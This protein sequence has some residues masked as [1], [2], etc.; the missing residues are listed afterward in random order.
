[1]REEDYIFDY[2]M[3]DK[4]NEKDG[5]LLD[6]EKQYLK[7]VEVKEITGHEAMDCLK[8]LKRMD[9]NI[10][11]TVKYLCQISNDTVEI[12]Q[13]RESYKDD[14]YPSIKDLINKPIRNKKEIIEYMKGCK[15][16]AAAPAVVIDLINPEIKLGELY[17]MT[18][19]KYS[20]R[21]DV[22]YYF[23]KYDMELPEEFIHHALRH[24]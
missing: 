13:I 1:M 11:D 4:I 23:E 20:W 7:V 3:K 18:D 17:M 2:F 22:I 21:S 6:G 19:G 10:Q 24:L 8:A 12:G 14:K 5:Y 9:W 15:I 16:Q